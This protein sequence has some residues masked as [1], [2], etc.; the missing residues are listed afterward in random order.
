MG[1][2]GNGNW[3][4]GNGR[5]WEC[6]K[7]F[8]H[9]SSILFS[10]AAVHTCCCSRPSLII[11]YTTTDFL[12]ADTYLKSIFHDP[13][14]ATYRL[15]VLASIN[16]NQKDVFLRRKT[17]LSFCWPAW[18]LAFIAPPMISPTPRVMSWRKT[19]FRLLIGP[20]YKRWLHR[21]V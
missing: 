10:F 5:E 21:H 8:P 12:P 18:K 1:M 2:G 17:S 14:A 6:W 13:I 3:I 16:V 11:H 15:V 20:Q 19:S 7:P 4:Y 9:I